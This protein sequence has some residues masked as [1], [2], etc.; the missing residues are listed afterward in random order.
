MT[1][2]VQE[3]RLNDLLLRRKYCCGPSSLSLRIRQYGE[4]GLLLVVTAIVHLVLVA[5]ISH[6]LV[7]LLLTIAFQD[8]YSFNILSESALDVDDIWF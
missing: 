2:S 1:L 7:S 6:M 4:T 8:T 5:A 3:F